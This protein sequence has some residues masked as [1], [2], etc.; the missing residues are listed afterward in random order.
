MAR[1][2]MATTL[3]GAVDVPP[4]Q[5]GDLEGGTGHAGGG[6][7]AGGGKHDKGWIASKREDKYWRRVMSEKNKNHCA[8]SLFAFDC[9]LP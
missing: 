8:S 4:G 7:G 2:S 5:Y 6:G 9:V 3:G 1:S